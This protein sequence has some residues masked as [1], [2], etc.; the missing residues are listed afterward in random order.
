MAGA[1]ALVRP[2]E[3]AVG[4]QIGQ[5]QTV[6]LYQEGDGEVDLH[7][8]VWEAPLGVVLLVFQDPV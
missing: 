1:L 5:V 7:Q 6:V 8:R 2:T 3:E 4:S